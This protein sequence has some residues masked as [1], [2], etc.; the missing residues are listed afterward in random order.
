[1]AEEGSRQTRRSE[2][3]VRAEQ[4]RFSSFVAVAIYLMTLAALAYVAV[5]SHTMY[6]NP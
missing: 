4:K 6:Y 5:A 2:M 3:R 1:V